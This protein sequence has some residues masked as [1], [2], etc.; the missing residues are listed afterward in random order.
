MKQSIKDNPKAKFTTKLGSTY[1]ARFLEKNRILD[2]SAG[3]ASAVV[4]EKSKELNEH[5]KNDMR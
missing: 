2:V 3:Y 4:W 5:N 1:V